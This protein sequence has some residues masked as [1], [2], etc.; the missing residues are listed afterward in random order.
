MG[1]ATHA[2]KQKHQFGPSLWATHPIAGNRK[3]G[4]PH[5]LGPDPISFGSIRNTAGHEKG[6][7]MTLIA[8]ILAVSFGLL[9]AACAFAGQPVKQALDEIQEE[10]AK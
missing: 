7:R 5:G 2:E 6:Q 4:R 9:M 1:Y 3:A 10:D 8:A